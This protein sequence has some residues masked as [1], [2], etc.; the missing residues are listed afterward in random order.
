MT[1]PNPTSRRA[2]CLG[3]GM[4]LPPD[5]VAF[6][7]L[8]PLLH[9]EVDYF[10]VA[11]ETTWRPG[12]DG[13]LGGNGF[14]ARFLELG[15]RTGKPFVAHGVGL[16]LGGASARDRPRKR[17]WLDAIARDQALFR[18]E[19][20]TD[21]LS[22]TAPDG[23][24]LTLPLP[25]LMTARQARVVARNLAELQARVP[26]VGVETTAQLFTLGSPMDEPA[27]VRRLVARPG[28]HVLLDLHNVH[29]MAVNF[30]FD[31]RAY[32]DQLPLDS[33]IEIHVSGGSRS[34]AGWL[35]GGRRVR[36]DSHDAAVPAPVWEL[37]AWVRPR[38][39]GLRGVTLERIE[40]SIGRSDVPALRGELRRIRKVM[41]W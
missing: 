15:A 39:R 7:R 12:P 26:V 5:E 20:Y 1:K 30:G 23:H 18:Y 35:P 8:Q 3:V 16:S 31:A 4:V 41:A 28:V 27:F 9:G 38:C 36:L 11:P 32:L 17:A 14:H 37:L 10:E 40:G 29:T 22:V 13:S 21:H 24:A 19:W 6:A 2:R 34:R 33:V 25:V